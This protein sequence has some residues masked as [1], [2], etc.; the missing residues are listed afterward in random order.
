MEITTNIFFSESDVR[1]ILCKHLEKKGYR[2]IKD[3]IINVKSP[4]DV[5]S[6]ATPGDCIGIHTKVVKIKS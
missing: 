1:T 2:V 6:G 3:M 5:P 4:K